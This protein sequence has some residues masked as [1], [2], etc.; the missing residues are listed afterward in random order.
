ML[1]DQ[2]NLIYRLLIIN[3]SCW[4]TSKKDD[5]SASMQANFDQNKIQVIY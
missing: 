5:F 3:Y 2:T 1:K 4:K